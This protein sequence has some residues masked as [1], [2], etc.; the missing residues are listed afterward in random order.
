M[1]DVI[2]GIQFVK[3][4]NKQIN[5]NGQQIPLAYYN[6]VVSIRDVKIFCSGMKITRSWKLTDVKNYFGIK[7]NK[8]RV[9]KTLESYRDIIFNKQ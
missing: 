5:Y 7:G 6:L 2:N 9:L 4:L 3:D 8:E 1:A